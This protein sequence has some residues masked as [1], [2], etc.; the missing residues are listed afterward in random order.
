MAARSRVSASGA[1]PTEVTKLEQDEAR[2]HSRTSCLMVFT[3]AS[4]G[5]TPA[6]VFV[7]SIEGAEEL[8]LADKAAKTPYRWKASRLCLPRRQDLGRP[9]VA[10]DVT[11]RSADPVRGHAI[12]RDTPV[13]CAERPIGGIHLVRIR[14][15][16]GVRRLL[17]TGSGKWQISTS[18]GSWPRWR[19]DGR[20]IFYLALSTQDL[21]AV[22]LFRHRTAVRC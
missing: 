6:G 1:T 12:Q 7:G 14:A 5:T 13:V 10:A 3:A 21:M 8:L 19:R 4:R 2:H 18:T 15:Q 11:D 22:S 9:V 16:R 20:E 17:S